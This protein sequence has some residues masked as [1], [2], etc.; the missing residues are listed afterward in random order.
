MIANRANID[1]IRQLR[2]GMLWDSAHLAAIMPAIFPNAR[3][4]FVE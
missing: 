1:V 2:S 3:H 4:S